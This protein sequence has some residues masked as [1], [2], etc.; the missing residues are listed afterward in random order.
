MNNTMTQLQRNKLQGWSVCSVQCN[1][2]HAVQHPEHGT[3]TDGACGQQPPSGNIRTDSS[4][5]AK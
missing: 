3:L 2:N 5:F 1:P 4:N